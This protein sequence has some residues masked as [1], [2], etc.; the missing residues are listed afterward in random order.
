MG[1][2][3]YKVYTDPGYSG[4]SLDRPALQSLIKASQ[5]HSF[6]KVVV[7]KLDRLSRSQRDT[8]TL[9]EE[10]FNANGVD[11][12][13]MNENFDTST[14]F[15][16]ATIGILSV[17]AQL[18]REQIKERMKM[19]RAARAKSGK[20]MGSHFVPIGY[21]KSG[22]SLVVN[23]YEAMQ[24]RKIFQMFTSGASIK[25]ICKWLID[26][27]Y[28]H[29][30]GHW[31]DKAIRRV[32]LSK[33]YLG[34]VLFDGEW[35][36]SDHEPL[37]TE[38]MYEKAQDLLHE[39]AERYALN[40]RPGKASSYLA[41]LLICKRC[42]GKYHR[43]N[44]KYQSYYYC[45][46]RSK[47]S[48][49]L[50]RDPSCKNKNWRMDILDQMIFDQIRQLSLDPDYV[51]EQEQVKDNSGILTQEI[52]H[53][54][55]QISRLLDLYGLDQLPMDQLQQKISD[56]SARKSQLEKQ[57]QAPVVKMDKSSA[58]DLAKGFDQILD[59]GSFEEIRAVLFALI[60]KI[61]IDGEDIEI[62]WRF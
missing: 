37:I 41:G 51:P 27:G 50:I 25:S 14:P 29:K 59:H 32:L 6:Q 53:I 16:R 11:F 40:I 2:T 44:G 60:D 42:G 47:R 28:S 38:E 36:P 7:Y 34:Y 49:H 43:I 13:S 39:R 12:V 58:I 24:V 33:T 20:W 19:G 4:A 46:S 9:L 21:D 8:L 1:W 57:L 35:Y 31:N 62:H 61:Y 48:P 30:H 55:R 22:D 10:V 17:F 23:E 3:V 26:S 54:D 18:E 52:S 5:R 15:G 56:L 45:D